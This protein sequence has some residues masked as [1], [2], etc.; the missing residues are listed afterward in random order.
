MA[1]EV[2]GGAVDHQI[3]AEFERALVIGR[4]EGVVGDRQRAAR[5]GDFRR[6]AQV[7]QVH[8]RIGRRLGV[9]HLVFG[10]HGRANAAVSVWATCVTSTP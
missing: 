10:A 5:V 1:V 4:G 8:R 7:G 6:G 2:L 9:D 3:V